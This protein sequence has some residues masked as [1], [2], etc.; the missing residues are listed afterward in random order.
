MG[1]P[2]YYGWLKK[3]QLWQARG[4]VE[5]PWTTQTVD[6]LYVDMNSVIHPACHEDFNTVVTGD[7]EGQSDTQLFESVMAAVDRLVALT[8][9]RKLLYLS[10][11]GVAPAAKMKQQRH[12]RLRSSR[13]QQELAEIETGLLLGKRARNEPVPPFSLFDADGRAWDSNI[14]T[15]GTEFMTGLSEYM[16]RAIAERVE[17]DP[18]WSQFHVILSDASVPGEGEHKILEY[19]RLHDAASFEEEQAADVDADEDKQQHRPLQQQPQQQQQQQL[20]QPSREQ[21]GSRRRPKV[22][23]QETG[24]QRQANKKENAKTVAERRHFVHI[25]AGEDAD[26]TV[27]TLSTH[28]RHMGVIRN[29]AQQDAMT[30]RSARKLLFEPPVFAAATASEDGL[31][32]HAFRV[33]DIDKVG[34]IFK[35]KLQGFLTGDA[36]GKSTIM[37][38]GADLSD[39]SSG[40]AW[41][42]GTATMSRSEGGVDEARSSSVASTDT[43][44]IT[45]TS[46]IS[47]AANAS[48]DR[49]LDDLHVLFFMAGN[50]FIPFVPNID[51]RENVLA[52]VVELYAKTVLAKGMHIVDPASKR[53]D[54]VALRA[55]LGA[56]VLHW[57]RQIVDVEPE[58]VQDL[59]EKD[60]LVTLSTA[61]RKNKWIGFKNTTMCL[62]YETRGWCQHRNRCERLHGAEVPRE[63]S[64]HSILAHV[65]SFALTQSEPLL[66]KRKDGPLGNDNQFGNGSFRLRQGFNQAATVGWVDGVLEMKLSNLDKIELTNVK[67]LADALGLNALSESDALTLRVAPGTAGGRA[68]A[69]ANRDVLATLYREEMA[70]VSATM[71][72]YH[73]AVAKANDLALSQDARRA[74]AAK[75]PLAT[76]AEEGP[77][78]TAAA[79]NAA[80]DRDSGS[81]PSK[82]GEQPGSSSGRGMSRYMYYLDK[83]DI[84][85]R[86]AQGKD[87]VREIAHEYLRGMQFVARYYFHGVPSWSWKYPYH[88]APCVS[89]L[90]KV[91]DSKL[92]PEAYDH[93]PLTE[94]HSPVEQLMLVLP[95]AS[96]SALPSAAAALVHDP[97]ISEMFPEPEAVELDPNGRRFRWQWVTL[98]AHIDTDA[99][100]SK[101]AVTRDKWTERELRRDATGAPKLFTR[102]ALLG[103]H[104]SASA[105]AR[106]ESPAGLGAALPLQGAVPGIRGT[107]LNPKSQRAGNVILFDYV[108]HR[109][110]RNL[111][112]GFRGALGPY[113]ALGSRGA[114]A[115]LGAPGALGARLAGLVAR[116]LR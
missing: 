66:D 40:T 16:E 104:R 47:S 91:V 75:A 53:I 69:L 21:P 94:P 2:S 105:L 67:A 111:G 37:A 32:R 46:T 93:W 114:L 96:M 78:A 49:A 31:A 17:K 83:F 65:C 50:D 52:V 70:D 9:P 85:I 101:V 112:G 106:G 72:N 113:G 56:L 19:L 68:W 108:Q 15:P 13:A 7:L 4:D 116:T 100:V 60:E 38:P 39:S 24:N 20:E 44:T 62:S 80:G 82:P 22:P 77:L 86:D 1:I 45:S 3:Y 88:Y 29:L 103:D 26:L 55:L 51:I 74:H 48:L 10:I 59:L 33:I 11:D 71:E 54:P 27:L 35:S 64:L 110:V 84:D 97:D 92:S 87:K 63:R 30:A 25:I 18:L 89:D 81:G 115:A 12:R 109:Q 34:D 57:E 95:K 23:E 5:L 102:P 14:I 76:V 6:N 90:L 8:Q 99:V 98:L 43:S 79:E 61:I 28:L 58:L 73:A 42:G 36:S 41:H 107:A